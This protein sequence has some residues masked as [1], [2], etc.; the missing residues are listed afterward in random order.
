MRILVVEDEVKTSGFLKKGFAELSIVADVVEDGEGGLN[1]AYTGDYDFIIL[2]VMLPKRDGW[3]VIAELRRRGKE[4]PVIMLT[5]R[6]AV[7]D[8]IRGLEL[9]VDDYLVKPFSF[10]EL[11]ARIRTILRRGPT[12]KQEVMHVADLEIDLVRQRVT[13]GGKRLDLTHKE[14]SLLS[15]L[16]SKSGE[17][18]SKMRIAERIWNSD[19]DDYAKTSNII[20]VHMARLRAKVDEPFENKLIHTVRGMGYVLEER[21]PCIGSH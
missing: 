11:Y 19:Y 17:V 2:D 13:R 3:S 8:R 20:D 10:F 4:T 9:G 21:Q 6:D 14:F 15:L 5:A 7:P 16:V 1:R 18:I 12:L